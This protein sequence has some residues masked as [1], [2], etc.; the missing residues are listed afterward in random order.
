[1]FLIYENAESKA[2][3]LLDI[4]EEEK[5]K[6]GLFQ[7]HRLSRN[8]LEPAQDSINNAKQFLG[9]VQEVLKKKNII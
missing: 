8:N 9:T 5:E 6:R 1:M 7:Y 4:Y 3:E 2:S